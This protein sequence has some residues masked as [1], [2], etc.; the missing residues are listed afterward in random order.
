MTEVTMTVNGKT[1]SGSVE[2]RTLLVEFI[3]NDLHL[4]GTHVGCDTSQ[5]GACAI[6][7]DGKLVKAC[8]MFALEADGAEVSTIEGQA[9]DDG[10]LM[11]YSKLSK[12]ITVYSVAFALREWS[13]QLL[14]YLTRI[15][16]PLSL[17]LES[18][19]RVIFV[20]A[21]GIIISSKQF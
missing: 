13:W 16:N 11:L 10:S 2:G 21:Q 3:R 14:I 5:C 12:S 17:K 18:T 7:V 1:V 8:T 20:D 9:N 15:L 6:H 19:W 4:T